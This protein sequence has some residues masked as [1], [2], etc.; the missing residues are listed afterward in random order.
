MRPCALASVTI[1]ALGLTACSGN[2]FAPAGGVQTAS[3]T[4]SHFK[5]GRF[6]PMWSRYASLIPVE[7]R[8][9][10]FA[11]TIREIAARPNR[12]RHRH[13]SGIYVSEFAITSILGYPN[14]NLKNHAPS[15][16]VP[17]ASFVNDIAVDP[18]GYLIVP[19]GTSNDGGSI[20]VFRGPGMCGSQDGPAVSDPYGQPADAA[21]A[22]AS[23]GTIVVGNIFDR[24]GAPGSISLCSGVSGYGCY[25]N[26]T[27]PAMYEVAGI[28]LAKNGDCWASS[29][30]SAGIA[31]LTYFRGCS[32]SGQQATGYLNNFYGGLDIDDAGNLVSISAFNAEMYVYKGCNPACTLVGGPFPM[33][34]SSLYGHLDKYSKNFVAGDF[35]FGQVDVYKYTP[36]SLTYSYSFNNGL[37]GGY[38]VEGAAFNPRSDE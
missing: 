5:N 6:I 2:G 27:N 34:N 19:S 33:L 18:K 21:S 4:Q 10:G 35:A 32:G 20:A 22:N 26:L 24:S 3:G 28:A 15:C 11:A 8:P 9:G 31:T 13:T 7:L 29:S 14:P 12:R 17:G 38:I 36:T 25:A 37:V 1:F 30:D 23:V 16:T